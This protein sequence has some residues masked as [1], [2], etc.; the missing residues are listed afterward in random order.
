MRPPRRAAVVLAH[1]PYVLPSGGGVVGY[2]LGH[3]R[4]EAREPDGVCRFALL[5]LVPPGHAAGPV[6][7][8]P[9]LAAAAC[10]VV[11]CAPAGTWSGSVATAGTACCCRRRRPAGTQPLV[12]ALIALDGCRGCRSLLA[13]CAGCGAGVHGAALAAFADRA[14]TTGVICGTAPATACVI[15]VVAP[16]TPRGGRVVLTGSNSMS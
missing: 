15:A 13:L 1:L 8:A 2:F 10:G 3:M 7:A 9:N 16:L 14:A 6:A 12:V 5:L 11:R 4:E